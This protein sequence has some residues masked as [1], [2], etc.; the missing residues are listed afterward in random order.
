MEDVEGWSQG[1][2]MDGGYVDGRLTEKL[3]VPQGWQDHKTCERRGGVSGC[4]RNTV[5]LS[6][7]RKAWGVSRG[8]WHF[9]VVLYFCH[10]L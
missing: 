3:N 5:W 4:C 1:R 7:P 8:T 6:L 9:F 10:S 2:W